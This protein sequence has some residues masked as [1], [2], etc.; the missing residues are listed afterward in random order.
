[1]VL[2]KVLIVA[3]FLLALGALALHTRIHP[4]YEVEESEQVVEQKPTPQANKPEPRKSFSDENFL[5]GLFCFI[6]LFLVTGLFCSR[7]TAA[8][9]FMLNGLLAIFGIIMMS[10]FTIAHLWGT[11]ASLA[12]WIYLKS[13]LP[14]ICILLADF[15]I[16]KAVYD[17]YRIM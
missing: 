2:R 1:M 3:L 15:F 6:D 16:G 5:A 7:K 13:T 4:V 12:D 14:D 10:H 8:Y 9:A 11:G 17:S